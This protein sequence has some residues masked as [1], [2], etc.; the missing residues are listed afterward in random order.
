[1]RYQPF[2]APDGPAIL[3]P[4]SPGPASCVS[5]SNVPRNVSMSPSLIPGPLTLTFSACGGPGSVITGLNE[6]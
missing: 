2:D 1:M 3:T 6:T 5:T 4:R